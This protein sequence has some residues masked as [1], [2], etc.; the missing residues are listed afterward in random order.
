MTSEHE[1]NTTSSSKNFSSE[2]F[3]SRNSSSRGSDSNN[4]DDRNPRSGKRFVKEAYDVVKQAASLGAKI[5]M[6]FTILDVIVSFFAGTV[7]ANT[8]NIIFNLVI[9]FAC[10]AAIAIFNKLRL[11]MWLRWL[12]AYMSVLLIMF[13]YF[14][15]AGVVI[16]GEAGG[17]ATVYI[18][19]II[20]VTIVFVLI[21]VV[22]WV[23]SRLKVRGKGAG[24]DTAT[25]A[26]LEAGTETKAKAVETDHDPR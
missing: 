23:S 3:D 11:A 25:D 5:F 15:I 6:G 10:I 4:S 13:M 18:N 9:I 20:F 19:T 2:S 17:T 12:L 22:D 24:T 1:Q 16:L 8:E 14:W 26:E 21:E 7:D